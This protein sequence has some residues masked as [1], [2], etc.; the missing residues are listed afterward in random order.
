MDF[1][2]YYSVDLIPGKTSKCFPFFLQ[3]LK[4]ESLV[5][6]SGF[7]ACVTTLP[8]DINIR[9]TKPLAA[10]SVAK[11][12]N[13]FSFQNKP[14]PNAGGLAQKPEAT[15]ELEECGA[16]G[17]QLLSP[18]SPL[19]VCPHPRS[20]PGNDKRPCMSLLFTT[21]HCTPTAP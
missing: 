15:R 12:K 3:V 7:T 8:D 4:S 18:A 1:P 17:A 10:A 16:T 19:P 2:L 5:T 14:K 11:Q 20:H 21:E 6:T 9:T 13:L